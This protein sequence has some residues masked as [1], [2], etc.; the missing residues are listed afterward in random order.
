MRKIK[1]IVVAV[2]V[3]VV[4]GAVAARQG[5]HMLK[6]GAQAYMYGYSLVLMDTTR[7]VMT[8]GEQA[9]ANH[10]SLVR[11]FPDH[12]FRQVVRPNCD[13]LYSTAWIDLSKEPIILSVPDMGDRY[14]VM[15]F[16]DAWTNVFAYIGKRTT[17]SGPGHY[18]L[19]GPGWNGTVPEGLQAIQ[20]PTNMTW[21]IGR[22]QT[23][24]KHDFP[25]VHRL[26][27]Q[28]TLTPLS[29]WKKG[30]P[31]PGFAKASDPSDSRAKSPMA[32]V[33][34]MDAH[35]YFSMLARLMGEQPPAVADGP[36]LKT[37]AEFGVVP[38]VPFNL[39]ELGFMR[40]L[41]LTKAVDVTRGKLDEIARSDRSSENKWAVIREGIGAY[42]TH[43]DVRALVSM[44][45]LGALEPAEAAYPN[46]NMDSTGQ[47]LSGGHHYRIH[48]DAGKTPPVDAF[49]SLTMYD[50]RGFLI[51][52]PIRRY[53]I[54]DRD[55]LE[56]L[57]ILIQYEQPDT[58]SSNWLPAPAD[59]FAVTMRLYLPKAEFLDGTWKLPPI[60]RIKE[61]L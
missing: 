5:I 31:N 18:M 46:A 24:G 13:T 21:L 15:P 23:N 39:K 38:G 44:V 47:P 40:R 37:L 49:W 53:A 14:Y 22:I 36:V 1:W 57:D 9:P 27:D 41:M 7:Q 55:S 4:I 43:Y 33:A 32:M 54:G 26:Q 50:E 19:A 16:M 25:N 59:A 6:D 30:Q 42:G 56:L 58:K 20:A 34:G 48:F 51:D 35:E 61:T 3:L 45:G 12:L 52:N 2:V 10:F 28:I 17:G 8:D 29:R 11:V 60:E